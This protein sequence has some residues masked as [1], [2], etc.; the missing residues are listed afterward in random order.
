MPPVDVPFSCTCGRV[1]GIVRSVAPNRGNHVRCYCRSCQT[2]ANVLGYES[3]LDDFGGTSVFQ[4]MPSRVDYEAGLENLACFRLSPKGLLRWYASCCN[5]PLV[6]MPDASW[7]PIA[8]LNLERVK[9][10]DHTAFGPIIAVH[11][12]A[13]AQDAPADLNDFGLKRAGIK[14]FGRA[15]K[16]R[17]RRDAM[18]PYFDRAGKISVSPRILTLEERR[19]AEPD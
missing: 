11:Q 1:H 7:F 19:A 17:L 16:A 3:A 18:A 6:T 2:A 8:G 15:F 4:T 12:S 5:A 9:Q 14:M 10:S 13:C